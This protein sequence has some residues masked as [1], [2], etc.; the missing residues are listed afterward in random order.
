MFR[1]QQNPFDEAVG[2]LSLASYVSMVPR[3][4]YLN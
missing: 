4:D 2:E 3:H 1:A